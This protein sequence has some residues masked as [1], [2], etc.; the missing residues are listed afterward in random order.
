MNYSPLLGIPDA[1]WESH[2]LPLLIGHNFATTFVGIF[3]SEQE[4][5][6]A[7]GISRAIQITMNRV[8]LSSSI[9]SLSVPAALM[10]LVAIHSD[11]QVHKDHYYENMLSNLQCYLNPHKGKVPVILISSL[12]DEWQGP[13]KI[14]VPLLSYDQFEIPNPVSDK[15]SIHF[16]DNAGIRVDR[17][18]KKNFHWFAQFL[19]GI[20]Q[21]Q[22]YDLEMMAEPANLLGLIESNPPLLIVYLLS[23]SRHKTVLGAYLFKPKPKDG[24][25]FVG[26]IYGETRLVGRYKNSEIVYNITSSEFFMGLKIALAA[27]VDDDDDNAAFY[28][29][30]WHNVGDNIVLWEQWR[31]NAVHDGKSPTKHKNNWY[32]LGLSYWS[33][34]PVEALLLF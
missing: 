18:T 22:Q 17:C 30:V 15:A 12:D 1:Q 3:R 8:S 31:K 32:T 33:R 7:L 34:N 11:F 21:S 13:S 28:P 23:D 16:P 5:L 19:I 9:L 29:F 24:L 27:M 20:H 2:I 10:D 6:V 25:H 26:S 4:E 14:L